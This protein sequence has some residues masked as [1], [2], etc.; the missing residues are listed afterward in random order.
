MDKNIYVML[1]FVVC[2]FGFIASAGVLIG[3]LASGTITMP[4]FAIGLTFSVLTLT[5]IIVILS[6]ICCPYYCSCCEKYRIM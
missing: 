3:S 4:M 5:G 2:M 1:G 6:F